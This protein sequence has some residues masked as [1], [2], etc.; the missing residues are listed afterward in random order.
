MK[1]LLSPW[2]GKSKGFSFSPSSSTSTSQENKGKKQRVK[3]LHHNQRPHLVNIQLNVREDGVKNEESAQCDHPNC[4][5]NQTVVEGISVDGSHC[6]RC[7][8]GTNKN[9]EGHSLTIS[10]GNHHNND[11]DDEHHDDDDQNTAEGIDDPNDVSE[12]DEGSCIKPIFR[13]GYLP[14]L[15]GIG[16]DEGLGGNKRKKNNGRPLCRG[17]NNGR[18]RDHVAKD[19]DSLSVSMVARIPENWSTASGIATTRSN[20]TTTKPSTSLNCLHSA[21]VYRDDGSDGTSRKKDKNSRFFYT[22]SAVS[23]TARGLIDD[24]HHSIVPLP[25]ILDRAKS[26]SAVFFGSTA[27][28]AAST[29]AASSSSNCHNNTSINSGG[30]ASTTPSKSSNGTAVG[31][32]IVCLCHSSSKTPIFANDVNRHLYTTLVGVLSSKKKS[33]TAS[34]SSPANNPATCS[35]CSVKVS[36]Y[37]ILNAFVLLIEF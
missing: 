34:S 20:I 27:A 7:G 11:L 13:S 31:K 15:L 4:A 33:T 3:I 9:G 19:E 23:S 12:D 28:A 36:L 10:L 18:V 29:S 22:S 8:K 21:K 17:N 26:A 30:S 24:D 16:N 1:K 35:L 6:V 32:Q 2:I 5:S 14:M 37:Y 25:C